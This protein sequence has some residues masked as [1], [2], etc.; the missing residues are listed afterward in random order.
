MNEICY[1]L[2]ASVTLLNLVKNVL[3]AKTFYIVGKF[4]AQFPH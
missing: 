2:E 4:C 3:A 1:I